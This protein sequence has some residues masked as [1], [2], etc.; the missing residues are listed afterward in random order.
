M[1]GT[2]VF[3]VAAPLCGGAEGGG[4]EGQR[5]SPDRGRCEG[6]R[7]R[8]SNVG[9]VGRRRAGGGTPVSDRSGYA[10]PLP[11]PVREAAV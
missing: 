11:L 2:P 3:F 4:A 1:R 9:C 6:Q 8:R 5:R 7:E 10:R